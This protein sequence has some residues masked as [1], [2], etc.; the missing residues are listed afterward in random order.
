MKRNTKTDLAHVKLLIED[1]GFEAPWE[2]TDISNYFIALVAPSRLVSCK[3]FLSDYADK[4]TMFEKR[5]FRE[6]DL[7]VRKVLSHLVFVLQLRN[8]SL[9][10]DPAD[11]KTVAVRIANNP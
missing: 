7:S 10:Q 4:L 1:S 9:F 6:K 3:P 11:L 2:T 8:N 5:M